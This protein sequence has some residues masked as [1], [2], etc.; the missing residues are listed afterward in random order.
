[1][2]TIV[3]FSTGGVCALEVM[4]SGVGSVCVTVVV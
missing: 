3:L 2:L 4:T 1:M